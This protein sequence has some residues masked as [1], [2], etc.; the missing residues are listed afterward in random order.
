MV[1]D[2]MTV[3]GPIAPNQLGFTSMHEHIISD[4]SYYGKLAKKSLPKPE[5]SWFPSNSNEPVVI[6]NL[7]YLT[8]GYHNTSLDNTKLDEELMTSEVNDFK[9]AG[10]SAILELS[11]PGIRGDVEALRRISKKTGVH[12]IASTGLY[13]EESWIAKYHD[14]SVEDFVNYMKR[15]VEHGIEGTDIRAGHLKFAPNSLSLKEEKMVRAIARTSNE[16]GLSATI[17]HGLHM[18][19]DHG[20]KMTNIL[21]E[22]GINPERIVFAHMDKLVFNYPESYLLKNFLINPSS[23]RL[24]L[25]YAKELLDK[26]FTLSFDTFGHNWNYEVIGL[27]NQTDYE[28]LAGLVALIKEGYSKQLVIGCDVYTKTCTRRYGGTGYSRLLNFVV[29]TLRMLGISEV[30]ILNITMKNPICLLTR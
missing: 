14:M 23:R 5:K 30:D 13:A 15:E 17:H 11:V 6:E 10:G 18:T 22:E 2:I 28:R 12:V 24:E 29:P 19:K 1:K 27:M 25:D 16:T 3:L 8:H 20:R 26:G 9:I 21:T 7:S 4:V